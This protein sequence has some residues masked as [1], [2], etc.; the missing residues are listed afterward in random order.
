[1]K[2]TR[3]RDSIIGL[4]DVVLVG[5]PL[6]LLALVFR[7]HGIGDQSLWQDEAWEVWLSSLPLASIVRLLPQ[8][9][10]SPPLYH[11]VLHEWMTVFGRSALAV[12][13]LSA[14]G[15]ALAIPLVYALG[16][17]LADRRTA[18]IAALLVLINPFHIWYSQETRSYSVVATLVVGA[19][20]CLL[21]WMETSRRLWGVLL[22]LLDAILLYTQSTTIL[23]VAAQVTYIGVTLYRRRQWDFTPV[24]PIVAALIMWAPWV[25][26]MVQQ[27]N[28][29]QTTWIPFT[30]LSD[31]RDFMQQLTG[32]D[33]QP[34]LAGYDPVRLVIAVIFLACAVLSLRKGWPE[35]LLLISP[36]IVLFLFGTHQHLWGP[37]TVL[38]AEFGIALLAARTLARLPFSIGGC[39]TALIVLGT[40]IGL[41]DTPAKEPWRG[42]AA[43]LC[44]HASPG[45]VVYVL[46]PYALAPLAYA[47]ME[48]PCPELFLWPNQPLP[49]TPDG[50]LNRIFTGPIRSDTTGAWLAGQE[51]P[52]DKI[53]DRRLVARRAR[54]WLIRRDSFHVPWQ[55]VS[56]FDVTPGS[57][58]AF[59]GLFIAYADITPTMPAPQPVGTNPASGSVV[60]DL[61][62]FSKIYSHTSELRFFSDNVGFLGGDASRLSRTDTGTTRPQSFIYSV[63]KLR[64]FEV[65]AYFWPRAAMGN[66]TF[67]TSRDARTWTTLTPNISPRGGDWKKVVYAGQR[68]PAGTRYLKIQ[69]PSGAAPYW[70]PQVS[71]VTLTW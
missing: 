17:R 14:V 1:M 47:T 4:P 20:W 51:S 3:L 65:T 54:I 29:G 69:F 41:S 45:D 50:F 35:A 8:Y 55:A 58:V 28:N 15:G 2:A 52:S 48:R 21:Q 53:F 37:R 26:T 16:R 44:T 30:T 56:I 6:F 63:P 33:R 59:Q 24:L 40:L 11:F 9:D 25:P 7:V 66:F 32:M 39:L 71:S 27:A 5:V 43:L 23:V 67:Y 12:R 36:A 22:F 68:I 70:D 34:S 49:R 10:T 13:L 38:F 61:K 57:P 60:D 18:F 64:S 31:A 46:P 62:D 42:A 19:V